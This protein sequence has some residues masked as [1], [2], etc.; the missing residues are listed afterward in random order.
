M[1]SEVALQFLSCPVD[2]S[3]LQDNNRQYL[4][5][6]ISLSSCHYTPLSIT[7]CDLLILFA[8]CKN[9]LQRFLRA[10][11]VWP[12]LS[13]IQPTISFFLDGTVVLMVLDVYFF[14][15]LGP[16]LIHAAT[17]AGMQIRS[18]AVPFDQMLGRRR[19]SW[20]YGCLGG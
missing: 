12:Q 8:V 11:A 3:L 7:I 18:T 1:Q 20:W 14:L 5:Y 6:L 9:R 17:L 4:I 2:M 13:T 10:L 16:F 15:F 19:L